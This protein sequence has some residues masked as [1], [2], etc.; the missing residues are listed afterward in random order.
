M[1][2]ALTP[3][4][5]VLVDQYFGT[6]LTRSSDD[7][8]FPVLLI[9]NVS[10]NSQHCYSLSPSSSRSADDLGFGSKP[11]FPRRPTMSSTAYRRGLDPV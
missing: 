9:L 8:S 2:V 6:K 4:G 11:F 5:F 1:Q 10:L 3:V 7:E